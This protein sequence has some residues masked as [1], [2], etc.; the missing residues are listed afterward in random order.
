LLVPPQEL[1]AGWEPVRNF[2]GVQKDEEPP[3]PDA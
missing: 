1:P 2:A 3:L